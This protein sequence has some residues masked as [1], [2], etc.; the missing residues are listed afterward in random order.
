MLTRIRPPSSWR[1]VLA[2]IALAML[3]SAGLAQRCGDTLTR[4]LTLATDL[5]CS[6]GWTA[7]VIGRPGITLDLNGKTLSGTRALSGIHL[8]DVH[9]VEI[10]G[11]GRIEGFWSGINGLRANGLRVTNLDF[12][13]LGSGITLSH[14]DS[15]WIENNR[16]NGVQ[17]EA[18]ALGSP[19]IGHGGGSGGHV[20]ASNHISDGGNGITLCGSAQSHS[21]I[22]ANTL[23][24]L[25]DYGL[26]LRDQSGGHR[27]HGNRFIEIGNTGIVA[28]GSS[29]NDFSSNEFHEGRV[30]IA[31]IPEWVGL[32]ASASATAEVY[33]NFVRFNRVLK[34]ETGVSLGLGLSA[35]PL[36]FKNWIH[37]NRFESGRT[38]IY[39]APDAHHNDARSNVYPR[40]PM[41]V[42]DHGTGNLY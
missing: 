38:G 12:S 25:R 1:T 8:G 11:P 9:S 16:F 3:P 41:P 34:Y 20:I 31:M 17:T 13:N 27:V 21:L 5:H 6:T 7:L 42:S 10:R 24:R 29:E 22:Q 2:L 39:F 14:S 28:R 37:Q 30:A 19:L 33:F 15:V 35:S 4:D 32:C 36:V 26:H 18:I 40:T 23:Q